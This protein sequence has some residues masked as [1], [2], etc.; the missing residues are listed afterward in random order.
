MKNGYGK[1]K[2]WGYR[3]NVDL[4]NKLIYNVIINSCL[5]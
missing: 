5:T 1:M 3:E 4:S 2:G